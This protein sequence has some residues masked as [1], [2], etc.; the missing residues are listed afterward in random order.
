MVTHDP[1]AAAFGDR[2]VQIRDGLVASCEAV[3]HH[4][5]AVSEEVGP[6]RPRRAAL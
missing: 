2:L 3:G 1:N 6:A 4:R 5:P